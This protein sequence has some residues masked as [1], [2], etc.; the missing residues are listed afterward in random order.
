VG[1]FEH[2]A[3][4]KDI[5]RL[6]EIAD[7]LIA[8]HYPE[9]Q[10]HSVPYLELFRL[11]CK[12]SA[13]LVAQWQSVGFCHGVLNSDNISVLGLTLDYGPFG[14][15]DHFELNHIC[16]H[17]DQGGRYAYSRQPQIMYWNMAC[18][19]SAFLPLIELNGDREKARSMLQEALEVFPTTY[20][21]ALQNLFRQKLG[22]ATTQ[23]SDIELIER[24]LQTMH[25]S[26]VD[27][28]SFFRKLADI[29]ID[30]KLEQIT[31]RDD[32]IDRSSIDSWFS[33]YL[34]RLKAESSN[35]ETRRAAMNLVNPKFILRNHL[36][37]AAIDKAK[38]DDFSE[39]KTLLQ[40]LQKPYDEQVAYEAYA[41]PPAPHL[42]RVEV[43]C[44]S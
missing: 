41:P 35:N 8:S 25:D 22:F 15:L 3:S 12:R 39:I 7:F 43:S 10:T 33:E 37:Q 4:L 30:Q 6:K 26:R 28:T 21:N 29:K 34:D 42:Q 2:F 13:Q 36:A 40:I 44:S 18:L 32:F 23:E 9:C 31:L 16:N 5:A 20:S 14:F 27:F 1:H 19:A 11:I 24:L 17:S 38:E